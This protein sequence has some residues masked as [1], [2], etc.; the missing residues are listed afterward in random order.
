MERAGP[1]VQPVQPAMVT[2]RWAKL[3]LLLLLLVLVLPVLPLHHRYRARA[4]REMGATVDEGVT[5][6]AN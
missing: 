3:V 4:A 5:P 6:Q 2:D 1:R